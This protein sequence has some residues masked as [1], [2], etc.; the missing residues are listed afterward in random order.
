MRLVGSRNAQAI[1][2]LTADQLR[3]WSGRRGLVS[4]EIPARGKGTQARFSWQNLLLL[5]I[6]ATLKSQTHVELAAYRDDIEVLQERISDRSFHSLWNSAVVFGD[7]SPLVLERRQILEHESDQPYIFVSLRPHLHAITG[8]LGI[9]EPVAQLP[10]FPV[11][12][13][14]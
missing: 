12:G 14:R 13:L 7:A 10:L 3:E 1:T 2:G 9:Q 5:R 11:I 4:P 8:G 6:C